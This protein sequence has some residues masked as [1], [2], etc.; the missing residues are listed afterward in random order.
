LIEPEP[1]PIEK[2]LFSLDI[3]PTGERFREKF[4]KFTPFPYERHGGE[5]FLR[6]NE[7]DIEFVKT[8]YADSNGATADAA[9][10]E[11]ATTG[12]D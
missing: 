5:G 10:A 4:L 9:G 7:A 3:R 2:H 1:Q 6:D 12:D 11:A 8:N